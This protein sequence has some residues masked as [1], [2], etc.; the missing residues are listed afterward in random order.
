MDIYTFP[1]PDE[2]R[3][4]RR[5]LVEWTDEAR[6]SAACYIG[7]DRAPG[8]AWLPFCGQHR[9]SRALDRSNHQVALEALEAL[10]DAVHVEGTRH[11]AV[12]WT[13]TIVVPLTES[14]LREVCELAAALARY[15]VLDESHWSELECN[16]FDEWWDDEWHRY[17]DDESMEWLEST[18]AHDHPLCEASEHLYADLCDA[19]GTAATECDGYSIDHADTGAAEYAAERWFAELFELEDYNAS[20]IPG[21]RDLFGNEWEP[22]PVGL[23]HRDAWS[24]R[25]L[26]ESAVAA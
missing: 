9:D 16:E 11:W 19:M 2:W 6:S 22:F 17:V 14:V 26:A 25:R 12:G 7:P 3:E 18:T 1:H 10:S 20:Q 15:P 21:Q 23:W 5:L 24:I 13:D 4:A 8:T